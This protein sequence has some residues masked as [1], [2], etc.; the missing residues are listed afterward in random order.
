M[1]LN[2]EDKEEFKKLFIKLTT[3]ENDR[4][5]K[6]YGPLVEGIKD[7]NRP[8]ALKYFLVKVVRNSIFAL[9]VVFL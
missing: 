3:K 1:P 5:A 7:H 2:E 9:S 4:F 6:K 8:L